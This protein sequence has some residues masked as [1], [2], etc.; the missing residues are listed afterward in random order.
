MWP[1]Q[2]EIA[3]FPS[4]QGNAALRILSFSPLLAIFACFS[5]YSGNPCFILQL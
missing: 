5:P 4:P 2:R 1:L 3:K